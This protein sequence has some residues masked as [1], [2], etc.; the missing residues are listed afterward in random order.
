[1]KRLQ[2][3]ILILLFGVITA[4]AHPNFTGYSGAPGSRGQCASSCHGSSGG[5]IEVSGFP[6]E[7]FPG[8]TYTVMV[9]HASGSTIKQ[10]NGS[11]RVGTGSN[12][13]GEI[14]A[15]VN[16]ATYSR[17]E[18][19]NGVHLSSNDQNNATFLWTAPQS[20]TGEVRLYIAGHQGNY[21]GQNSRITLIANE[22]TT[23]ID[24]NSSKLPGDF[25]LLGNYPNPFNASTAIKYV[26]PA[27][28]DVKVEIFDMLGRKVEVLTD[29]NQQPGPHSVVW[30]ASAQSS[31]VYFYRISAG[32]YSQTMRMTLLK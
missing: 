20:G 24:D 15:G 27:A 1:M 13:A 17:S 2:I 31:G 10:F 11:C 23:G 19:A 14:S 7:Y 29:E 9:T 16:T 5:T 3:T 32:D 18:E 12:T 26:L 4:F 6:T 28:A 30:N 8:E 25:A 22:V 21:S